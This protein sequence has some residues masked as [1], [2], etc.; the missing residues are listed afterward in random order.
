MP[1]TQSIAFSKAALA[2]SAKLLRNAASVCRL[3][4]YA[5]ALPDG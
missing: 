1:K 3:V 2:A 5:S 4:R